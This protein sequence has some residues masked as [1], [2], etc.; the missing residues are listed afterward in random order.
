MMMKYRFLLSL[1]LASCCLSITVY[2]DFFPTEEDLFTSDAT[3]FD[4]LDTNFDDNALPNITRSADDLAA[5][6]AFTSVIKINNIISQSIYLKTNPVNTRSL[7]SLPNYI[8]YHSDQLNKDFFFNFYCLYNETAK[9][10]FTKN[11]TNIGTYLNLNTEDFLEKIDAQ[12]LGLNVPQ[13]LELF[14]TGKIQERRVGLLFQFFKNYGDWSFDATTPLTYQESNF[15]FSDSEQSIIEREISKFTGTTSSS[16]DRSFFEKLAVSDRVGFG[17]LKLKAGYGLISDNFLKFKAGF[18]CTLPT[19][20]AFAKGLLGSD[21][22]DP[23]DTPPVLNLTQ[24]FNWSQGDTPEDTAQLTAFSKDFALKAIRRLGAVVLDQSLGNWHH[25]ILGGFFDGKIIYNNSF[26]CLF[27]GE[28][29]YSIPKNELRFFNQLKNPADFTTAALLNPV[30]S[31]PPGPDQEAA[32]AI[33]MEFLDINAVSSMF[34]TAAHA[35]ISPGVQLQFLIGPRFEAGAYLLHLGYNIWHICQEQINNVKPI[36]SALYPLNIP[37]ATLFA[38][39][40]QKLFARFDYSIITPRHIWLVAV[41]VDQT[42]GSSGIGK[43]FNC[44]LELSVDF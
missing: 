24:V 22:R 30:T 26:S 42:L 12:E 2:A 31:L 15:Y 40:Q 25:P 33:Q 38:A 14:Q 1:L 44:A 27:A 35:K 7:D 17:N 10:N 16:V 5:L 43:D 19:S 9:Q 34:P 6:T 36:E 23:L 21:F 18:V 28:V 11:S 20:F 37:D 3:F 39:T 13:I 32:A 29:L 4:D 41:C 8:I